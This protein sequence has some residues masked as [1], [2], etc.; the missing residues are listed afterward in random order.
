ML[1]I[2][3]YG[4][5]CHLLF[6]FCYFSKFLIPLFLLFFGLPMGYVNTVGLSPSLFIVFVSIWFCLTFLVA[7]SK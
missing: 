2:N 3:V 6:V 5:S 7:P 1:T 4:L